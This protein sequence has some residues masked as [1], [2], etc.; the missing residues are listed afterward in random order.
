MRKT[1]AIVIAIVVAIVF[2][3]IGFVLGESSM[4]SRYIKNSESEINEEVKPSEQDIYTI[5]ATELHNQL[6]TALSA[7]H[8]YPVFE[9]DVNT[10]DTFVS[11]NVN[12]AYGKLVEDENH[13]YEKYYQTML[14]DY[15]AILEIAKNIDGLERIDVSFNGGDVF[16]WAYKHEG[17]ENE[18]WR[19]LNEDFSSFVDYAY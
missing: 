17:W 18:S 11:L 1:T 7:T 9:F 13:S 10:S 3:L 6:E 2:G 15:E 5:P 8:T 12:V 16:V 19:C 4:Q 14:L